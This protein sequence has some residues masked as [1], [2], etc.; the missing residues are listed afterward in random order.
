MQ[1]ASYCRQNCQTYFIVVNKLR[2]PYQS[3]GGDPHATRNIVACSGEFG[4][5]QGEFRYGKV[6]QISLCK[7]SKRG[8]D[9]HG[10]GS[11]AGS[12]R[13]QK[14]EQTLQEGP[15]DHTSLVTSQPN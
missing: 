9:G 3:N 2:L 8:H 7:V 11:K 5:G 14:C 1:G 6:A 10:Q 4:G 12:G 15:P 13:N